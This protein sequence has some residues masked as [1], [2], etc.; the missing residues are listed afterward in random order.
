MRN[1]YA[2]YPR[3]STCGLWQSGICNVIKLQV[4]NL[5]IIKKLSLRECY[6]FAN[7]NILM[8]TFPSFSFKYR[9]IFSIFFTRNS[10]KRDKY[11]N[12]INNGQCKFHL[13]A[14][15]GF[16]PLLFVQ[17][18]FFTWAARAWYTHKGRSSCF[19]HLLVLFWG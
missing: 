13:P 10:D 2:Q 9:E 12:I 14:S 15:E 6:L 16:W 8:R 19:F 11:F 3:Y 17:R 7:A 4:R 1:L 18:M 5:V